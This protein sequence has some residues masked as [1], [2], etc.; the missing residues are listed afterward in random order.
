MSSPREPNEA[1]SSKSKGKAVDPSEDL[2]ISDGGGN[3]DEANKDKEDMEPINEENAVQP[4]N[5]ATSFKAKKVFGMHKVQ[6]SVRRGND[7]SNYE[8]IFPEDPMYA[9][10]VPNARVWRTLLRLQRV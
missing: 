6:P 1:S 10:M 7:P 3:A 2:N 4:P 8:D 9:E 5:P